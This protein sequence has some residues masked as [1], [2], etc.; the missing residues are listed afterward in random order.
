MSETVNVKVKHAFTMAS[1]GSSHHRGDVLDVPADLL[2]KLLNLDYVELTE[3]ETEPPVEEP[4]AENESDT[5]ESSPEAPQ[6]P[7]EDTTEGVSISDVKPRR[8]RPKKSQ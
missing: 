5:P 3:S 2:P 7:D 8:G 6:G 1:D 4:P